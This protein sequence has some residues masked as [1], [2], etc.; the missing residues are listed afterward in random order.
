MPGSWC[1][2]RWRRKPSSPTLKEFSTRSFWSGECLYLCL[3]ARRYSMILARHIWQKDP[4]TI[5]NADSVSESHTRVLESLVDSE[6]GLQP[7]KRGPTGPTVER[8]HTCAAGHLGERDETF[9]RN[10]KLS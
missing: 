5:E 1:A 2:G 3:H 7:L 8:L 10:I 6:N 4:R 9:F